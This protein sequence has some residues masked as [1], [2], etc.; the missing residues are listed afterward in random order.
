MKQTIRLT[1]SEL[2]QMIEESINE[3]M[4]DEGLWNQLKQGTMAAFG[5]GDMG[6]KNY[7]NRQTRSGNGGLNL[8]QR[9][10]AF[11]QNFKSQGVI[12]N[13]NEIVNYLQKL[14]DS[15]VCT[16]QS[17]LGEVWGAMNQQKAQATRKGSSA[18]NAIYK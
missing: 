2:K 1:E 11:K 17:T 8:G 3:A 16:W 15:G 18:Q 12:D 7:Y 5:K 14:V 4:V 10:N 6:S 13:A 9:A